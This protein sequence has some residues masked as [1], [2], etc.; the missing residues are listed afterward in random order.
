MM[1]EK[2]YSRIE[3]KCVNCALILDLDPLCSAQL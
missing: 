2:W 1:I 3:G